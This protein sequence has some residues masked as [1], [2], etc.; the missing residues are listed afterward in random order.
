MAIVD[1]VNNGANGDAH[2][3][4]DKSI[5]AG[6]ADD[7][8]V[9]SACL[10][11][12]E[13]GDE[14][15]F[16]DGCDVAVHQKCYDVKKIPDGK[17]FC[18]PCKKGLIAGSSI[19]QLCSTKSGIL[20]ATDKDEE[21]VHS[22]CST[23]IPEVFWS[24]ASEMHVLASS[25]SAPQ[26]QM[27]P[28]LSHVP[29]ARWKLKCEI[30]QK[31][32][33]AALQCAY[34]RCVR[35]VH[36][37]C[38]VHGQGKSNSNSNS[39]SSSKPAFFDIPE[40]NEL[41]V[42]CA[43]HIALARADFASKDQNADTKKAATKAPVS[44]SGDKARVKRNTAKEKSGK[45]S[46]KKLK[47]VVSKKLKMEVPQVSSSAERQE[48]ADSYSGLNIETESDSETESELGDGDDDDDMVGVG[49]G[50][51]CEVCIG[52][53][54]S[55]RNEIIQCDGCKEWAHQSC[56]NIK[57]IPSGSWFCHPCK[58]KKTK[59]LLQCAL[60][61]ERG[62]MMMETEDSSKWVHR[63]C[64]NW[65]PKV[66]IDARFKV[67]DVSLVDK[68]R[69][70]LPCSICDRVGPAGVQC[71]WKKCLKSIHP[72]CAVRKNKGVCDST[73]SGFQWIDNELNVDGVCKL[74]C[75]KHIGSA[76]DEFDALKKPVPK[77]SA[78][79]LMKKSLNPRKNVRVRKRKWIE[80]SADDVLEDVDE[81]AQSSGDL[82]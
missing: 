27:A 81:D 28:N 7:D 54:S 35:A 58:N 57:T 25:S 66:T 30:C 68:A 17:W 61:G 80:V 38:F 1:D 48:I 73:N 18:D 19:C 75:E 76:I 50:V 53:D 47:K 72:R 51:V 79:T 42:Y 21:Y 62:G 65:V 43:A 70:K 64:A 5:G 36:P 82:F 39:A 12:R 77:K 41:N 45:A 14:I 29:Q 60:C 6:T 59:T 3:A 78:R 44:S 4:T 20:V 2:I 69:F 22:L 33:S 40:E 8:I 56:Y 10:G 11:D 74:Y 71:S 34:G 31:K 23:Y 63:Q 16:C 15:L 49:V 26:M 37:T 32:N 24:G 67:A 55:A 13:P 9:C 52:G 46:S